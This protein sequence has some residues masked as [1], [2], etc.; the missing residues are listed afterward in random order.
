M[1]QQIGAA[2]MRKL[3]KKIARE[4]PSLGFAIVVFEFH[5]PGIANY[6]SNA[7]RQDMILALKETIT[8]LEEKN[9]FKTPEE[10]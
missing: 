10:N 7:K 6:L 4:I 2:A 9:D 3:G 5:H 8:I 1:S